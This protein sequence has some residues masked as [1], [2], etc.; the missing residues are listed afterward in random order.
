M[1]KKTVE[2][3]AVMINGVITSDRK[4]IKEVMESILKTENLLC[5]F[6]FIRRE[7]F[8]FMEAFDLWKQYKFLERPILFKMTEQQWERYRKDGLAH[9]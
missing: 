9:G 1:A 2:I 6:K 3:P 8:Q 4:V 7:V 5:E